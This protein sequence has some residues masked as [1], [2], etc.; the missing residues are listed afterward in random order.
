MSQHSR[1][2]LMTCCRTSQRIRQQI[3]PATPTNTGV[4]P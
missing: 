2:R 1:G 3:P 4:R